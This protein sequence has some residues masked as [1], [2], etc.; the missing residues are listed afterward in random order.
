M[1]PPSD[2]EIGRALQD[3]ATTIAKSLTAI[4]AG[5][6]VDMRS[7][8]LCSSAFA[9]LVAPGIPAFLKLMV[10]N[11][12]TFWLWTN[13][14]PVWITP[15]EHVVLID[16]LGAHITI[17]M[18]RVQTQEVHRPYLLVCIVLRLSDKFNS[19]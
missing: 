18:D 3:I 7:R 13:T 6:E 11:A 10:F 9:L 14:I 1:R 16:L 4:S 19:H 2:I 8:L 5:R 15:M 17:S 12:A